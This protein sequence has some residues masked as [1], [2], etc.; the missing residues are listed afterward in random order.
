M[1]SI[2]H[3]SDL[4]RSADDPI[5]N[6]TLVAAVLADRDRYRTET[7]EIPSPNAIV[8]SGDL[9]QGASL[10]QVDYGN[11]LAR[12]YAAARDLLATLTERLLE[13]DRRRIVIVPGN[14]DCCWNTAKSTM[15]AVAR[16]DMPT[17]VRSA[18]RATDSSY[19][20][21]WDE[22]QLYRIAESAQYSRRFDAYWDFLEDFYRGSGLSFPIDRERGFNLFA[23]DDGR[24]VVAA[25]E[26][27]YGNDCF[28]RRGA[29]PDDAVAKCN[30]ALRD[31]HDLSRLRVAV[32]HHSINGPA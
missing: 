29:I 11:E 3:I 21:S 12:Q 25:F 16:A 7:P 32:W 30:L 14:H 26:S 17:D 15:H 10:Q 22:C 24:I 9:I 27:L 1:F 4:H 18:L 2:L 6:A 19:R 20:W 13:G 8:V 23:L 5:T 31:S 28:S